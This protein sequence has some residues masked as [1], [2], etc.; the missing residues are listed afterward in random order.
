MKI[1]KISKELNIDLLATN[2]SHFTK[3]NEV[4]T[5]DTLSCVQTEKTKEETNRIRYS[6]TEF[7]KFANEMVEMFIDHIPP[8]LSFSAL[9]NSQE[10]GI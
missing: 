4:E 1:R 7:L 9:D 6:G 8:I 2:D 5:H 10:I 3:K